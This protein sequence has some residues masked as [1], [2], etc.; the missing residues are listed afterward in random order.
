MVHGKETKGSRGQTIS[1]RIPRLQP[2]ASK[3]SSSTLDNF[4]TKLW[5][6]S[7][8]ARPLSFLPTGRKQRQAKPKIF[9]QALIPVG[10]K[11]ESWA[12]LPFRPEVNSLIRPQRLRN[13]RANQG[14]NLLCPE[15]NSQPGHWMRKGRP[16]W[17]CSC[18]YS[19]G[20]A[21][22]LSFLTNRLS[23]P[24]ES[25]MADLDHCFSW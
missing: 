8:F 14:V 21:C 20:P 16:G 1:Q 12:S 24:K 19:L 3:H 15:G 23:V 17:H 13:I 11:D 6:G 9:E 25:L 10:R 2:T 18:K 5:T 4:E 22:L 7:P